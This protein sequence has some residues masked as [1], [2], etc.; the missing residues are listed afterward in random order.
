M[1][2]KKFSKPEQTSSSI[3]GWWHCKINNAGW[4]PVCD[5]LHKSAVR[6]KNAATDGEKAAGDRNSVLECK[7]PVAGSNGRWER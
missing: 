4:R 5:E 3:C 6:T 1:F 2:A 7:T